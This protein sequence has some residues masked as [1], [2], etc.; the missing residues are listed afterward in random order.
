MFSSSSSNGVDAALRG[1]GKLLDQQQRRGLPETSVWCPSTYPGDGVIAQC[2]GLSDP[3]LAG[4]CIYNSSGA[5]TRS[6]VV[7]D[8]SNGKRPKSKWPDPFA[9]NAG[10][11]W[12]KCKGGLLEC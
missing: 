12:C 10:D 9:V 1:G 5:Y 8:I 7:N 6:I 4:G 3:K 11:K 2:S